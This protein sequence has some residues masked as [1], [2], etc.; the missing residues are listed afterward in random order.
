ML[1]FSDFQ[2]FWVTVVTLFGTGDIDCVGAMR[3]ELGDYLSR[4]AAVP[5]ADVERD[6]TDDGREG[7]SSVDSDGRQYKSLGSS[8]CVF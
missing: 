4:K 1:C 2:V 5:K 8:K 6:W 7:E 3:N